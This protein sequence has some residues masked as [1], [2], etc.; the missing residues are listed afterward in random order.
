M[1]IISEKIDGK[2]ISVDIKSSN[3]KNAI[4]DTESKKLQITFINE[5]IYEYNDVPW[6]IFTRLR[7]SESQ[8]KFFNQSISKIYKYKKLK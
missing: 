8:G 3:L 6:D 5:S 1:G 7:M 4:Y 2:K